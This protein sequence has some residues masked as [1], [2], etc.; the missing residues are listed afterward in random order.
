MCKEGADPLPI[1]TP[2][3]TLLSAPPMLPVAKGGINERAASPSPWL[4]P[5][6]KLDLNT[7]KK[8]QFY[9]FRF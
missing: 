5:S 9:C 3:G 1:N 8:I 6:E 7:D 2:R 4:R